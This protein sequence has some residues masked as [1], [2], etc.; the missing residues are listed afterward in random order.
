MKNAVLGVVL[1]LT[2]GIAAWFFQGDRSPQP[3]PSQATNTEGESAKPELATGDGPEIRAVVPTEGGIAPSSPP[4]NG[5]EA[6]VPSP[7]AAV[8]LRGVLQ[9]PDGSPVAGA[10]CAWSI[11]ATGQ[12]M[13]GATATDR[14]GRFR[15]P[16]PT[17]AGG[18]IAVLRIRACW[19]DLGQPWVST[20]VA[21]PSSFPP[22]DHSIGWFEVQQLP[23]LANGRV[24]DELGAPVAG[25]R[26]YAMPEHVVLKSLTDPGVLERSACDTDSDGRWV[27]NGETPG[28]TIRIVARHPDYYQADSLAIAKGSRDV[29]VGLRQ[30]GRIAG[31]FEDLGARFR[32]RL[33]VDLSGPGVLGHLGP[34]NGPL[35]PSRRPC[36]SDGM[37]RIPVADDGTFAIGGLRPGR[38]DCSVLCIGLAQ[39]AA[40]IP[41]VVIEPGEVSRDPRLQ[42]IDLRGLRIIVLKVVDEHG[43]NAAGIAV[44]VR[45]AGAASWASV[46]TGPSGRAAA[47]TSVGVIDIEVQEGGYR[48][49]RMTSI[50]SDQVIKLSRGISTMLSFDLSEQELGEQYSAF[51]VAARLVRVEGGASFSSPPQSA[52]SVVKDGVTTELL[53]PV[54]GRY[55]VEVI[56]RVHDGPPLQM[57]KV[58]E[59][60]PGEIEIRDD[61]APAITGVRLGRHAVR[62]AISIIRVHFP[63]AGVIR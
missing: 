47:V 33:Y 16:G 13:S 48:R 40:R 60:E 14:E 32:K 12:S 53:V 1:L 54:A 63:M 36:G 4:G 22:G 28:D 51:E 8:T 44:G 19:E 6:P 50:R 61:T 5:V 3:L 62:K 27:I 59:V 20:E 57:R 2:V 34:T 23:R 39:P 56:V 45:E 18:E 25:V 30:A 37:L 29:Q 15:I 43:K 46:V 26:V 49:E 24:V 21:I 35:H 10:R 42:G 11:Q 31:E 17:E 7:P 41:N 52:L 9:M 55:R 58:R 38:V